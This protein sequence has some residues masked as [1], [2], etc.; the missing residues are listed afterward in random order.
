MR[1]AATGS[2][3]WRPS[4]TSGIHSCSCCGLSE[5]AMPL[6]KWQLVRASYR[7]R[8]NRTFFS[9]HT[10]LM[11]GMGT[12]NFSGTE[13]RFRSIRYDQNCF[14]TSNDSAIFTAR[15]ISTLPSSRSGV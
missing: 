13:I 15:T 3:V 11:C 9:P 10:K 6:N 5:K 4:I 2:V 1:V 8:R 7:F 14:D 12:I